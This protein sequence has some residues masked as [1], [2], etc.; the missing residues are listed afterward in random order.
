MERLNENKTPNMTRKILIRKK[1]I[2]RPKKRLIEV[3]TDDMK[4]RILQEVYP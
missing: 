1:N 4:K 2:G 3:I